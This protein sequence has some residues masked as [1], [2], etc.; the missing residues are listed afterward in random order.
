MSVFAFHIYHWCEIALLFTILSRVVNIKKEEDS[1]AV[2]Q[3]QYDA[4]ITALLADL[5]TQ[6]TAIDTAVQAMIDKN[7]AAATPLDFSAESAQIDAAQAK[8]DG[9]ATQL[10]TTPTPTAPAA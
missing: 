7:A 10:P 1:M 5:D 9:I 6:T 2:T 4:K 3:A 8:I